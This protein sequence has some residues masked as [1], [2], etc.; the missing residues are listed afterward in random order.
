MHCFELH[1]I[2]CGEW[3]TYQQ[4]LLSLALTPLHRIVNLHGPPKNNEMGFKGWGTPSKG[5]VM[6]AKQGQFSPL[7]Q[8]SPSS[9]MNTSFSPTSGVLDRLKAAFFYYS[10]RFKNTFLSHWCFLPTLTSKFLLK[11]LIILSSY[12]HTPLR[13][14]QCIKT[15]LFSSMNTEWDTSCKWSS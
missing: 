3:K 12:K 1:K 5:R 14:L 6:A 11:S 13:P 2:F 8:L 9:P 10:V 4:E 7:Q 15:N